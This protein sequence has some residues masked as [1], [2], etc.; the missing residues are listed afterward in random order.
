MAI[1]GGFL[2]TADFVLSDYIAMPRRY[3]RW[4]ARGCLPRLL[5]HFCDGVE[6]HDVEE[7]PE[8]PGIFAALES[9]AARTEQEFQRHE[10]VLDHEF[11]AAGWWFIRRTRGAENLWRRHAGDP[12]RIERAKRNALTI[13]ATAA[14]TYYN[15]FLPY[16]RDFI[17]DPVI[18]LTDE[19]IQDAEQ[20]LVDDEA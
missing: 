17:D 6:T 16:A 9:L 12:D 20:L 4:K 15:A 19:E 13:A 7:W 3:W 18:I 2:Q 5:E 11:V 10:R 1:F 14:L 8:R